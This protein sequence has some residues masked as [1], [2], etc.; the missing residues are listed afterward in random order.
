KCPLNPVDDEQREGQGEREYRAH[1]A[2]LETGAAHQASLRRRPILLARE[3]ADAHPFPPGGQVAVVSRLTL[4]RGGA[5]GEEQ[6]GPAAAR[7]L[8]LARQPVAQGGNEVIVGQ[9]IVL[10]S[11]QREQGHALARAA[12]LYLFRPF[13][14]GRRDEAE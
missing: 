6:L 1:A 14:I 2:V 9:L 10:T 4:P 11:P 3:E 8:L 12:G 13:G 7:L 5:L